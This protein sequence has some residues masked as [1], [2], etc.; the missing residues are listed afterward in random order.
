MN[1]MRKLAMLTFAVAATAAWGVNLQAQQPKGPAGKAGEDLDRAGRAIEKG[2]QRGVDNLPAQRPDGAAEKAGEK[3]DQAGRAI[4][5][6]LQRA[7]ESVRA[8]F[9]RTRETVHGMGVEARIYGRLHWDKALAESALDL[10]VQDGVAT[11]RGSV[12]NEAARAKAISLTRD[13][14]GVT[15]VVDQLTLAGETRTL[16]APAT[17]PAPA[18]APPR[19]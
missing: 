17:G 4:E 7:G 2:V 12:P 13:T 1:R 16:P 18:P 19:P 8:A 11:L 6:G 3:L 5:K 14:V 10:D 9:A 15:R